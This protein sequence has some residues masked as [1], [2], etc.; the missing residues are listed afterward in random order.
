MPSIKSHVKVPRKELDAV[1]N[2]FP[3]LLTLLW[4]HAGQRLTGIDPTDIEHYHRVRNKLY[5]DGT[6]LSVD[7]EHLLAYRQIVALLFKSL[8]NVNLDEPKS[9]P[10]LSRLILLCEKIQEILK[11]RRLAE[12]SLETELASDKS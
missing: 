4:E 10:A 12:S 6:G 5:H 11:Q 3:G 2:S 9:L 1:E 7:D 8:F